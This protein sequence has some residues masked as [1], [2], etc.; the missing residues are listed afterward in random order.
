MA[1][2]CILEMVKMAPI[3]CY[4]YFAMNFQA[5][6]R[7]LAL[8]RPMARAQEGLRAGGRNPLVG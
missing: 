7:G 1:L 8:I 4:V 2:N 6:G 5:S 3:L